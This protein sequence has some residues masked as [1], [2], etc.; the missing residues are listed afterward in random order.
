MFEQIELIERQR[1]SGHVAGAREIGHDLIGEG[2]TLGEA[3]KRV[4]PP[5]PSA[6]RHVLPERILAKAPHSRVA[7]GTAPSV[8]AR[9]VEMRHAT[10]IDK[11]VIG[12]AAADPSDAAH[13]AEPA[14]LGPQLA[15]G[16]AT[17]LRRGNVHH[18]PDGMRAIQRGSRAPHELGPLS[19]HK[20]HVTVERGRVPLDTG[21]IAEPQAVNQDG[22]VMV[23]QAS[24]LHCG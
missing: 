7:V 14:A 9:H 5:H 19:A 3:D 17:A 18:P 11:A 22:G 12:E 15:M 6:E 23:A 4:R 1:A 16:A 2:R 8:A 20:I 21:C 24:R 13:H 10:A